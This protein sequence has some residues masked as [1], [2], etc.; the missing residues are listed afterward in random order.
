[1]ANFGGTDFIGAGFI[2]LGTILHSLTNVVNEKFLDDDDLPPMSLCHIVGT[3]SILLYIGYFLIWVMPDFT[4]LV[5]DPITCFSDANWGFFFCF[6]FLFLWY[7]VFVFVFFL[8]GLLLLLLLDLNLF[9]CWI[10]CCWF[11]FCCC[12]CLDF[13]FC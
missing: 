13:F 11:V 8:I 4:K 6:F 12:C 10:C 9:G 7:F 3:Q 1:M 2:L 5:L